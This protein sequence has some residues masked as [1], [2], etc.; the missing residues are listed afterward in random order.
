MRP[1]KAQADST[2]TFRCTH[3]LRPQS[4]CEGAAGRTVRS[5]TAGDP[6]SHLPA[7]LCLQA[8]DDTLAHL[9]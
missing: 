2:L 6:Q 3:S 5:A 7:P 4:V 1:Y 8:G 9:L